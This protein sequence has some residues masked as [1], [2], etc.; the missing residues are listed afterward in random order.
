MKSKIPHLN[1]YIFDDDKTDIKIFKSFIQNEQLDVTVLEATNDDE[2]NLLLSSKVLS[3]DIIFIDYQIPGKGGMNWLVE[4]VKKNI[5]PIIM[6]TGRGDEETAAEAIKL[7]AF[8]YI[9]KDNISKY[10]L[11]TTIFN[12]LER[13]ETKKERDSLL[14]IAAHELRNPLATILGYAEILE[15]FDDITPE[16]AKEMY[17]IIRERCEH[18]L[19]II[20]SLLDVTRIEMGQINL[21]ILEINLYGLIE[22]LV[23]SI[24]LRADYKKIKLTVESFNNEIRLNLDPTRIEEVFSNLIENAI[25]FS[26]EN[27]K[28]TIKIWETES[29]IFVQVEDQGQGIKDEALKYLFNLF[30][31]VKIKSQPTAGEKSTGLGLAICKK[32]INMHGGEISVES[33]YGEGTKFIVRLPKSST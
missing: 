27:S 13:W 18:Q 21:K 3:P 16:Q 22:K 19:E 9:P 28:I 5:A 11:S 31:N 6:L 32:L 20:S 7:G 26:F 14:G 15:S 29:D 2:F 10:E 1:I 25:K 12:C 33:K 30:S 17:S 24:K 23:N 4:L 8:D